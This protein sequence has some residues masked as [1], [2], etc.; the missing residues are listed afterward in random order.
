MTMGGSRPDLVKDVIFSI[1]TNVR[2]T[3]GTMIGAGAS[4]VQKQ[5]ASGQTVGGVISHA[6]Q[7]ILQSAF[8]KY[9]KELVKETQK[10]SKSLLGRLGI[11]FSMA[12]ILKQSQ[13]FT[14]ILGSVFQIF[15]AMV[16]VFLAP[17]MPFFIRTLRGMVNLIPY[18]QEKG[19]Q[20]A[21]WI[22]NLAL[23]SNSFGEFIS[24]VVDDAAKA[25]VSG[26]GKGA[27]ATAKGYGTQLKNNPAVQDAT[28][29][30]IALS[31]FGPK[32]AI[33]GAIGGYMLNVSGFSRPFEHQYFD[34]SLRGGQSAQANREQAKKTNDVAYQG[35]FNTYFETEIATTESWDQ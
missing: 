32:G 1:L 24:K 34:D 15:G 19:E 4:A 7:K 20:F 12:S 16:D 11:Q 10:M 26:I 14:G 6:K 13:I 17:L 31:R 18:V 30:A 29:G 22:E 23:T 27:M 8:V 9:P 2:T 33:V 5:Q 35:N 21:A 28:L 25:I 3:A